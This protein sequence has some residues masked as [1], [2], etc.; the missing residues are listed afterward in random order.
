MALD[1]ANGVN[2]SKQSPE[3]YDCVIIGSGQAGLS[4]AGRLDAIGVTSYVILDRNE[5]IGDNW[6]NRYDSARLHVPREYSHLPFG[7]IF[8][9]Y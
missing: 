2:T 4:S 5:K 1:S 6:M 9:G 3:T 8:S 7:R